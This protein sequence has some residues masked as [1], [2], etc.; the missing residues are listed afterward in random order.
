MENRN[1]LRDL[2][3]WQKAVTLHADLIR[4]SLQPGVARHPWLAEQL[5]GSGR[6][7][8]GALAEG[9]GRRD[10]MDRAVYLP[11][12]K[13]EASQLLSMLAAA[14]QAGLVEAAAAEGLERRCEEILRLVAGL[15]RPRRPGGEGE[16]PVNG[17]REPWRRRPP[18][19]G[20]SPGGDPWDSRS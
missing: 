12:A 1:T 4:L 15:M 16:G 5:R 18:S 11:A 17:S 10:G 8:A 19:D 7:I 6:H 9:H 20:G 14:T 3:A 13:G 2:V